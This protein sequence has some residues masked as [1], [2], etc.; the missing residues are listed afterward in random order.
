M[1]I[2]CSKWIF[3][4]K[5]PSSVTQIN[6]VLIQVIL[7]HVYTIIYRFAHIRHGH[8]IIPR[9]SKQQT[10]ILMKSTTN[11]LYRL[12]NRLVSSIQSYPS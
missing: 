9:P 6:S 8:L 4:M 10:V 12:D 11:F 7:H 1:H 5:Y 2:I 3:P